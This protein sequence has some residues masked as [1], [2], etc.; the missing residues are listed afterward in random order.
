MKKLVLLSI[1]TVVGIFTIHSQDFQNSNNTGIDN[2]LSQ[3]DWSDIGSTQ[4]AIGIRSQKK[5][6]I[7]PIDLIKDYR[8]LILPKT[9]VQKLSNS[10]LSKMPVHKPDGVHRMRIYEIDSTIQF[11]IKMH[12]P[13]SY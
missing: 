7:A 11:Y 5:K 10:K 8:G 2:Q 4:F 12:V 1:F 9:P 3:K 6:T 13:D